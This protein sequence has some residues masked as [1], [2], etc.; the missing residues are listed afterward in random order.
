[1]PMVST[2]SAAISASCHR[3]PA[4]YDAWQLP[5]QWGVTPEDDRGKGETKL[6]VQHCSFT[7]ARDVTRPVE[8]RVYA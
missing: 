7:T 6:M 1:M 3:P 8:G 5:V 4:D 2:C